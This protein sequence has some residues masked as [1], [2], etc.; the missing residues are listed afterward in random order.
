M[1]RFLAVALF[2]SSALALAALVPK[3]APGPV[4]REAGA[5]RF[6]AGGTAVVDQPV[7]G[8]LYAAGGDLDIEG[9][10]GGDLVAAGGRVSVGGQA[11]QNLYAIGG[12]VALE[13]AV[14]RN[15]RIAGG[16]VQ[17][18]PRA[19]V[20]G[21]ASLAGGEVN[22]LGAVDGYLQAAGGRVYI[23]GTVGGD[24]DVAAQ[25][26]ELGPGARIGGAVRYLSRREIVLD[27]GAQVKGPIERRLAPAPRP[28]FGKA[29]HAFGWVWSA[30]LMLLA[31]A[32]VALLPQFFGAVAQ[33]ARRSFAWSL[34]RGFALLVSVPVAALLLL[35]TGIGA[36]LALL[37][38]VLYLALLLVG[39]A[40][41]GI[42]LGEAGLQRWRPASTRSWRVAAAVLGMLAIALLARIPV[43]GAVVCLVALSAGTGALGMQLRATPARV[44]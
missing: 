39:Y 27:P 26:V 33:T 3:G 44:A 34:V 21:G 42:A 40:S 13:G 4:V 22:V 24:V 37:A 14:A 2:T 36:P 9:Q 6:L 8:D 41:A 19:H 15:A 31:G 32:L 18:G 29:A 38:A 23:D 20:A 11:G 7:A 35:I 1:L 5:D 25:E 43:L 16:S 28:K 30:G 12:R 17:I 10:V